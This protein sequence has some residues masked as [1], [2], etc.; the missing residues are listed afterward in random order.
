MY[1]VFIYHYENENNPYSFWHKINL[2]MY[3]E[4][5]DWFP[6]NINK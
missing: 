1:N 2:F 3:N 4:M 6:G 5:L